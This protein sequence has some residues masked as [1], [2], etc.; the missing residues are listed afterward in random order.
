VLD[1]KVIDDQL[2]KEKEL[3]ARLQKTRAFAALTQEIKT[4]EAFKTAQGM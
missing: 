3:Y 1:P 4:Y 2:A